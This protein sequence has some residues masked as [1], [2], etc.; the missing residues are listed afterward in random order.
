MKDSFRVAASSDEERS[1]LMFSIM[2]AQDA[3]GEGGIEN[4]KLGAIQDVLG[5]Y[6]IETTIEQ[7]ADGI[8]IIRKLS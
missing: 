2:D 6:G 5:S 3:L 8:P 7:G 1:Q 4:Q